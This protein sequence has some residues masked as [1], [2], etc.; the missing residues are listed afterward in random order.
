MN[1]IAP[2]DLHLFDLDDTLITTREAY[3]QAQL[4]AIKSHF[5][6]IPPHEIDKTFD[7]LKEIIRTIGSGHVDLYLEVYF[8]NFS[9]FP[10]VSAKTIQRIKELYLDYFY[11]KIALFPGVEQFLKLLLNQNRKIALISNGKVSNQYKK[12]KV[13]GL[14]HFFRDSN[15][16]ISEQFPTKDK[17]PAPSMVLKAINDHNMV[18]EKTIFYGDKTVDIIAG[19]MAGVTTALYQ[20][21]PENTSFSPTI[22]TFTASSNPKIFQPNL[23]ISNWSIL[24]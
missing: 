11:P 19:N 7:A 2:Y 8:K 10:S 1:I 9:L 3:T 20:P 14:N 16:Y 6:E 15:V 24:K 4:Q 5:C 13:S 22:A 18:A 21:I 12:L 23:I 17:K